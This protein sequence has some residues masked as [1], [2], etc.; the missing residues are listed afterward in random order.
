[1]NKHPCERTGQSIVFLRFKR[2]HYQLFPTNQFSSYLCRCCYLCMKNKYQGPLAGPAGRSKCNLFGSPWALE[3]E[4]Q[5]P[6]GS[7]YISLFIEKGKWR[8][9]WMQQ[10][11]LSRGIQAKDNLYN[12]CWRVISFALHLEGFWFIGRRCSSS[13]SSSSSS[14]RKCFRWLLRC[15]QLTSPPNR[16]KRFLPSFSSLSLSVFNWVNRVLLS[17]IELVKSIVFL[18]IRVN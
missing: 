13:S 6:K 11:L 9:F 2:I 16:S 12:N 4:S 10:P 7:C 1:M 8:H 15:R 3:V 5:G 18:V 17:V 14:L